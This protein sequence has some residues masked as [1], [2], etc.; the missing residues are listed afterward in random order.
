[1]RKE[2]THPKTRSILIT[3]FSCCIHLIDKPGKGGC[4]ESS[5]ISKAFKSPGKG[6]ENGVGETHVG[7]GRRCFP[8]PVG[9]M[10]YTAGNTIGRTNNV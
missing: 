7:R 2:A 8:F 3:W 5:K 10:M 4:E 9:Q 6:L 1:M